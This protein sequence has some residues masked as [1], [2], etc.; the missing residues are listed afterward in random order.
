MEAGFCPG[1]HPRLRGAGLSAGGREHDRPRRAGIAEAERVHLA[2][3]PRSGSDIHAFT[4]S[5]RVRGG[6]AGQVLSHL[7]SLLIDWEVEL[8]PFSR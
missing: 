8:F 2:S 7:F 5:S 4:Y 6:L 1:P 3:P